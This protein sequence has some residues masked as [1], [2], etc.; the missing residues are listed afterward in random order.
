MHTDERSRH[1]FTQCCRVFSSLPFRNSCPKFEPP[2]CLIICLGGLNT[3]I[4]V[5]I[6]CCCACLLKHSDPNLTPSGIVTLLNDGVNKCA[7]ALGPP[8]CLRS[9]A[10]V[11][12][13]GPVLR[14][15]YKCRASLCKS[16]WQLR[17]FLPSC[18]WSSCQCFSLAKG[19]S[20]SLGT[21]FLSPLL[22]EVYILPIP[23]CSEPIEEY[24]TA[25][26]P[27][28]KMTETVKLFAANR[29]K[30]KRFKCDSIE[31]MT[32][33]CVATLVQRWMR[34]GFLWSGDGSSGAPPFCLSH[35]NS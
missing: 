3:V 34:S 24:C 5:V 7:R 28:I 2:V 4:I 26:C 33:G 25:F 12:I 23:F 27:F 13:T 14:R 8:L 10:T 31:Q 35:S 30:W 15:V 18:S 29:E 21:L 19:F 17:R 9:E 11:M 32:S 16:S 22:A 1:S 6:L 20:A